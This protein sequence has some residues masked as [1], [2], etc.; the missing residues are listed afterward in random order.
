VRAAAFCAIRN[1]RLADGWR[2]W[3]EAAGMMGD[4]L[5]EARAAGLVEL[6]L[7]E[8]RFGDRERGRAAVRDAARL[9]GNATLEGRLAA[10]LAE[11]GD[12]N[13]ARRLI[14]RAIADAPRATLLNDLWAPLARS[15]MFMAEGK[16]TAAVKV[17]PAV[18]RFERRWSDLGLQRA[19]AHAAAA[20]F[21]SAVAAYQ[22]I[23]DNPPAWPPSSS[24]YPAALIGL[25]RALAASGDRAAAR[26]A[27]ERFL[28]FWKGAD[29]DLRVL[30]EARRELA[31]LH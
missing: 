4:A 15:I 18:G 21:Q 6:G 22:R 13:A 29:R 16:S 7:A 2:L 3:G 5:R 25:A 9:L 24:G 14:E 12:A 17:L 23:V 27:Y 28:D 10:V 1:G 30:V 11:V 8:W 20:D 19:Q 31:T 26:Q